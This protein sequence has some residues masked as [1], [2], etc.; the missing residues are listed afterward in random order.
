MSS[1]KMILSFDGGATETRCG[2]YTPDGQ[3]LAEATAGPGNPAEYGIEA[4]ADTLLTLARNLGAKSCGMLA[5]GLAGA[6]LFEIRHALAQ[7]LAETLEVDR[8]LVLDDLSPLLLANTDREGGVL[9]LAGTGSCVLAL[10]SEQQLIRIGGR[11]RILGDLGSSYRIAEDALRA[12][13]MAVDGL[14]A[15][16]V[17]VSSLTEAAGVKSFPELVLWAAAADKRVLA[18]LSVVVDTAVQ[19]GDAVATAIF[20]KQAEGLA[21]QTHAAMI[22]A[23]LRSTGTLYLAGGLFENSTM[24]RT[25]YREALNALHIDSLDVIAPVRGHRAV[26]EVARRINMNDS[27]CLFVREALFTKH[28]LVASS[29]SEAPVV[30]Q[31]EQ[32]L[33]GEPPLDTL[34]PIEIVEAMLRQDASLPT[35]VSACRIT[36][37]SVIDH[38]ARIVQGGGRIIYI[39]AGTSGRLGVLDASECPPTFGVDPGVVV[40]LIAGED[41]ALRMSVE[42]AED[43][44]NA[45]VCDLDTL[46]PKLSASDLLIGIAASGRTPYVLAGLQHAKAKGAAT[47]LIAC[48]KVE[49]SPADYLIA[50]NTGPEILPGSTRLKA[51]TATKLVLNMI[52][53]GALTRAGFVHDGRMVAMRPVNQKLRERAIRIVHDLLGCSLEEASGW[54]NTAQGDIRTA[55]LMARVGVSREEAIRRLHDSGGRLRDALTLR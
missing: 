48:N 42:G 20:R 53:T 40:G 17:L 10:S 24:Y 37:A 19:A 41:R 50:L 4:V 8:L 39:G 15:N 13:A 54:L 6:G 33:Q 16:T 7:R 18:R 30:P 51:G 25:C 11:G 2:L 23:G 45:A 34:S 38:A 21:R 22:K 31:T 43:D 55:I 5:A 46:S 1:G 35:A 52:S 28:D 14:D 27:D 32:A 36:I 44:G 29:I 26:F 3:L 49:A 12:A 47:V 9:A